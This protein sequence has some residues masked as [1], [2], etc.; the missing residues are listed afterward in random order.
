MNGGKRRVIFRIITFVWVF[1]YVGY[2]ARKLLP[3]FDFAVIM[4]FFVVFFG[5]TLLSE[6][7]IFKEP[8]D[9]VIADNDRNS[10]LLMTLFYFLGLLYAAVDFGMHYTR[11]AALEPN[12]IGVGFIVFILSCVIRWIAFKQIGKFFN[13]R[14]SVYQAHRLVKT[15]IYSLVRH[16]IYLGNILGFLAIPLIFSSGGGL[17]IM[18]LTT[19]PATIY[20]I[21]LEEEFLLRHFGEEYKEYM[22][23]T[24]RLIPGIW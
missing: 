22:K 10:Y 20:R 23:N 3:G 24:K 21:N 2:S 4:G 19:V 14:V 17:A 8:D 5:W 18:L 1:A 6:M 7:Y 16:P 15:G 11:M 13:H 9:H 12:I